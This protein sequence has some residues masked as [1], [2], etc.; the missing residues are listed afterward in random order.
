[1]PDGLVVGAVAAGAAGVGAVGDGA[2]VS[3]VDLL[4]ARSSAE[5]SQHRITVVITA[6]DPTWTGIMRSPATT[7]NRAVAAGPWNTACN[8]SGATI[9]IPER[10]WATMA[11]RIRVLRKTGKQT[12]KPRHDAGVFF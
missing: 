6:A 8:D 7:P 3:A 11:V 4:P 10:I 5:R 12:K 9:Q 2:G 1:M